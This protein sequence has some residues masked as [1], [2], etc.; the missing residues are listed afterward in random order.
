MSAFEWLAKKVAR[1]FFPE[2]VEVSTEPD[3]AREFV[4]DAV[5]IRVVDRTKDEPH[6]GVCAVAGQLLRS[7]HLEDALRH[8]LRAL[9]RTM[10]YA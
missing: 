7:P 3:W 8:E 10:G 6:Y 9:A 2:Y 1:E 4:T 5:E